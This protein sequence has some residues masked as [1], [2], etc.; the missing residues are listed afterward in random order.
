MAYM[1]RLFRGSVLG[2]EVQCLKVLGLSLRD[3][4]VVMPSVV[5]VVVNM[6]FNPMVVALVFSPTALANH[7]FSLVVT[8]SPNGTWHA[9]C[10][11]LHFSRANE[12]TLVSFTV[13]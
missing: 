8:A 9:W 11:S 1:C 7:V 12:Q 3:Y 10:F 13:Y 4:A 5:Q 6:T 2:L